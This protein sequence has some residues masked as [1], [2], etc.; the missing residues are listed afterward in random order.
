MMGRSL[1][2]EVGC[3]FER[4]SELLGTS[5]T[6]NPLYAVFEH[7]A[8]RRKS[9]SHIQ[10]ATEV[11][12]DSTLLAVRWFGEHPQKSIAYRFSRALGEPISRTAQTISTTV[13]I[14]A[15]TAP[16]GTMQKELTANRGGWTTLE[17]LGSFLRIL[18]HRVRHFEYDEKMGGI[19]STPFSQLQLWT[20]VASQLHIL[21]RLWISDVTGYPRSHGDVLNRNEHMICVMGGV[22]PLIALDHGSG[23]SD[24]QAINNE[25][26]R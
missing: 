10:Y 16:Q 23:D 19:L 26:S 11:H 22:W 21:Q 5:K 18:I 7:P 25:A 17:L 3:Y 2:M 14:Q 13:Q 20:V 9:C 6:I 12:G 4:R 24:L 1:R 15:H 8:R